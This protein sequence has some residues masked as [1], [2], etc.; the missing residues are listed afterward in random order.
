MN[1]NNLLEIFP[2]I[3]F[4]PL[5]NLIVFGISFYF[6]N[7]FDRIISR[8][9]L[10]IYSLIAIIVNFYVPYTQYRALFLES[11]PT[12]PIILLLFSILSLIPIFRNNL[13]LSIRRIINISTVCVVIVLPFFYPVCRLDTGWEDH[14]HYF[15]LL[16]DHIH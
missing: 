2:G 1:I 3:P 8:A 7:R 15:L 13:R 4:S 11:I 12:F 9:I 5:S 14:Y 6:I 16:F 10:I